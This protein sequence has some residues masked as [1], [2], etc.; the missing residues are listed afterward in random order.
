MNRT[1]LFKSER[2]DS[3]VMLIV[4][5]FAIGCIFALGS[6]VKSCIYEHKEA[7]VKANHEAW[8]N[9]IKSKN[10]KVERE[11]PGNVVRY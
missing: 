9:S 7:K 8:V 10:K 5:V 2:G 3:Q 4:W 6:M 11:V 1:E